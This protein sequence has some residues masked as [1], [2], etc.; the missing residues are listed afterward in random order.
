MAADTIA[1][2]LI[3]DR[4]SLIEYLESGCKPRSEWGIGTEHEK[5][6]YQLSDLS[7]LPY[8]GNNGIRAMLRGLERFGWKPILEG[9]NIIGLTMEGQSISL[10]PGGQ[11]ELSGAIL[12]NIH[13]TCAEVNTHLSQVREVASDLKVGFIG[14]GMQPKWGREQIPV[15]P[16]Q[17]YDIM[18]AYMPKKGKHG[19]DMMLR[20]CTV[21]VNLDFESEID[22]VKKFRVGLALQPIATAL[23]ANSPF[24]D[25]RPSGYLSTRS[26]A[27]FNTDPDRC[28]IPQFVFETGMG[29]ERYVD[30]A[31]D[32]PMY[33]VFRDGRYLDVSG[34]S[35]RDFLK[36][37]LPGLPGEIP[38]LKDWS[39]HLTTIFTEVRL[40]QFLEMRGADAGPWNQLCALPALW[41]GL[42]YDSTSLDQAWDIIADW[43]FEEVRELRGEAGV[44][45]MA[46]S[47]R[48]MP[49]R[50]LAKKVVE[51]AR[52]GL[53]RRGCVDN[54]GTD[55]TGFLVPLAKVAQSGRTLSDELLDL[56]HGAWNETVD[57][58][59]KEFAY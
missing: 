55:E 25:G 44:N 19:L 5:I 41:V 56:Y 33:F 42:L 9:D 30:F 12:K 8:G 15:M 50:E 31:L 13:E 6:G 35:F 37:K 46:G 29:F 4:A 43:S 38:T 3:S 18:R 52:E 58:V 10:E 24:V 11:F 32:V 49:V 59:F 28:E 16:K 48:G 57:P 40:K 47:F 7:P 23:F 54:A 1:D 53:G 36:G 34:Q 22:M 14:I 45:G 51:L 39:D 17:R 20:T 26:N 2:E 27:W 21:Q